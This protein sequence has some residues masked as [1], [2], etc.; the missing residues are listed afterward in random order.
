MPP[1][2]ADPPPTTVNEL[3][4]AAPVGYLTT[5]PDGTIASAN[6]TLLG[7]LGAGGD[8][9]RGKRLQDI[10]TAGARIFYETHCAPLLQS[11][12]TL[13]QIAL[14]LR[15]SQGRRPALFDWRRID[16][17]D[18]A[19]IGYRVLVVDAT[20][21]RAYERELVAERE[22]ARQGAAALRDSEARFRA[23][24]EAVP[25]AVFTCDASGRATYYNNWVLDFTG[26]SADALL[27]DGWPSMLH[28]EDRDRAIAAWAAVTRS[29]D[30]YEVEYRIRRRDGA[31]RWFLGR[32]IPARDSK[33]RLLGW[34]GTCT[35]V[36]DLKTAKEDLT[37]SE[38]LLRMVQEAGGVGGFVR[39]LRTGE[40]TLSAVDQRIFGL[41]PG[42]S[43][44][45][46][47]AWSALLHP[48]DRNRVLL[49]IET[50]AAAGATGRQSEYRI[51]HPD[52]TV[53]FVEAQARFVRDAQGRALRCVGVHLD[54]TE[55]RQREAELRS[56]NEALETRV[57]E[58]VAAR[59]AAQAHL[60]HAQRME[61]L[62]QLAG[63]IA[64]D[65]NNVIQAVQGGAALIERRPGDPDGVRRLARMVSE[66][67]GRGASVTRRLLAFS[68]RGDLHTEA[69]NPVALLAGMHEVLVHTLGTG[70]GVRVEA[71]RGLP[72][73][74]ADK[75]QLETVLVNLATNARD[76]MAGNGQLTLAA[77]AEMVPHAPGARHPAGLKAGSYLRLS[78]TDT[79]A[80]MPAAVLARVT[81]PFFTT[82]EHGKGT[83]LG[84]AMAKGF[85][86][87]SG[88]GLQIVSAPGRGTTVSLWFPLAEGALPAAAPPSAPTEM[89]GGRGRRG[90]RVLLV[91]DDALV[92]EVTAEGLEAEGFALLVAA[93]GASALALLEEGEAAD[94]L[95]SDLSMPGMDGLTLIREAQRRRPRLPAILLTGFATNAAEIAIGG[96]MSGAFTLLRKPIEGRALAERVAMLL[97]G[98]AAGERRPG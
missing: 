8:E 22:R 76:A 18:G 67:A 95:I 96:A 11:E 3:Y 20:E 77:A 41:P 46:R 80:G 81:E 75:G 5:R 17:A 94:V 33:G 90:V 28:P 51:V 9:L 1:G 52:G 37:E 91:E 16:G 62:G 29:G 83:G 23:M 40:V 82:K 85:A 48:E 59:E 54:V 73:L 71:A 70:I 89:A 47:E 57:Q 44:L 15:G 2:H 32:S 63:G 7:W 19:L 58:E 31:Y 21:R 72:P 49:E 64:H 38:A 60:A 43:R 25:G 66:A 12:G 39:D 79:G 45:D 6:G 68:R 10:V 93:D 55:R 36:H 56:L 35:D 65:F 92:R 34:Y 27:G 30:P 42:T 98:V 97:E 78:V 61:A 4:D 13:R 24:A 26:L 53:R 86:E 69:V 88:G 87:Q 84:L 74:L 14:D 50:L